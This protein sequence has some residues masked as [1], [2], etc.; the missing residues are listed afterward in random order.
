MTDIGEAA[1]AVAMEELAAGVRE[2]GGNNRGP[3]VEEYQR[4][5]GGQPG[6]AWCA[7]FLVWCF[8]E[9]ARRLGVVTPFPR[10]RSALRVWTLA[11]P[12][13]HVVTP[14]RGRVAVL[15]HGKGLGHVSIIE[16]VHDDG[17]ISDVSGNTNSVGSR[18]GDSV[19]RHAWHPDNAQTERGAR[20]VGFVDFG[21]ALT[22]PLVA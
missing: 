3:R 10:T 11:D 14:A 20:L 15:D 8:R 16:A 18:A 22:R 6:E 2:V 9:A 1:L 17:S 12:V 13:C 4:A 5:A 19:A 21:K 7:A